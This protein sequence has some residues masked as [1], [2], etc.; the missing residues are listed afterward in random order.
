MKVIFKNL[1]HG[2][3]NFTTDIKELS[4]DELYKAVR[5]HLLSR[6]IEFCYNDET[7]KGVV[8]VGIVRPVGE[9]EVQE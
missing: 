8:F 9:F 4:Y 1:G 2:K 3:S 5:G 6:D 7:K